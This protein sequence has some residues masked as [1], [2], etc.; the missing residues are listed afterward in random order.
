LC[1]LEIS[2][3]TR[4]LLFITSS[5]TAL[6]RAIPLRIRKLASP[7]NDGGSFLLRAEFILDV[8]GAGATASNALDWEAIWRKSPES[9]KAREGLNRIHADGRARGAVKVT[10][11]SKFATSWMEQATSLLKRSFRFYWRD[12]RLPFIPPY[13][14]P[15]PE[16]SRPILWRNWYLTSSLVFSLG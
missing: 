3:K 15:D 16:L 5:R 14:S 1:T 4:P 8:I 9:E 7:W 6:V 2:A 13:T 11:T 12:V 10:F